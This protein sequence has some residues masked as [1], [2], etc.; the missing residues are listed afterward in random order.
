[1]AYEHSCVVDA[2]ISEVFGWHERPGAIRRLT[3]PWYPVRVVEEGSSLS[4]GR[5]VV[6][7]PLGLSWVADHQPD[8]YEPGRR[9]VDV[10]TTPILAEVLSWRHEHEFAEH[11]AGTTMVIDRV[12]TRLPNFRL[13]EMF[14]YRCRQLNGDLAA[15][16]AARA[17]HASPMTVAVTGTTGL[18]GSA[19]SAML[20]TGGHRVVHLVRRQ[21]VSGLVGG[22]EERRWDP[23]E[24]SPDLLEG[25][26]ALV[27]LAGA[28]I[29]GRFSESHKREISESRLGPTRALARLAA[30]AGTPVFVCASAIGYYGS[31]RGDEILTERS[32]AGQGFLSEVVGGWEAA[33]EPAVEA[34]CRV[35]QVRTGIVQSPKG[36]ALRL[37]RPLFAVGAGGRIGSGRQWTAWIGI[38]DLLDIYLRSLVDPD[39]EGPVNAVAPSPVRNAE[40]AATLARVL[41]R[42]ALLPVPAL[43]PRLLLGP[44]GEK[45]LTGASQRVLPER[46]LALG[47]PFR[48]PDLE[49]ALRHV[50]GR[51]APT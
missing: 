5:A 23:D 46:L 47:H 12:S 42:P 21:P 41:R 14:E 38:D 26:D 36:G 28:S 11:P 8:L 16:R 25:V 24:P 9:F 35:V 30:S 22:H 44:E 18:I 50:L 34:R 51:P 31:E 7:L 6:A 19:L 13:R 4:D 45:E 15:H 29:A 48:F 17:L 1:M 40:Y 10:L 43:G 2:P 3:P 33:T 32:G 37:M 39:L 20:T 49:P 27:H